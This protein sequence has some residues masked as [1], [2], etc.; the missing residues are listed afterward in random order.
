MAARQI[1][2]RGVC[3]QFDRVAVDARLHDCAVCVIIEVPGALSSVACGRYGPRRAASPEVLP[4]ADSE[5]AAVPAS[6]AA[7]A[8]CV[9]ERAP[10]TYPKGMIKAGSTKHGTSG[11]TPVSGARPGSPC[12][13]AIRAS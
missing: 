10:G 2:A 6:K 4:A 12:F 11:F 3:A 5:K 7:G 1:R 9:V 8:G 13:A